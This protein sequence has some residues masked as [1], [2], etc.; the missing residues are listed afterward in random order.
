MIEVKAKKKMAI[1]TKYWPAAPKCTVSA[2]WV[3]CVPV[4]P[5]PGSRR[6]GQ[7]DHHRGRGADQ[8]RVD[9]DAQRLDEALRRRDG[10]DRAS[11][12]AAMFGAEP[13]PASLENSPRLTPFS[14]AAATPPATPPAASW[15]PKALPTIVRDARLAPAPMWVIRT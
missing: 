4:T 11:A 12:Q 1:A 15:K 8:D 2:A 10:A 5:E 7:Q 3:S 6:A 14:I 13:M 9:E